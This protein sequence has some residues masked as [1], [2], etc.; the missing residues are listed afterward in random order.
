MKII[1]KQQNSFFIS[2]EETQFNDSN[3]IRESFQLPYTIETLKIFELNFIKFKGK[4][5]FSHFN[6]KIEINENQ[7]LIINN[8]IFYLKNHLLENPKT[9]TVFFFEQIPVNIDFEYFDFVNNISK[10]FAL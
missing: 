7:K 3:K 9:K 5:H 1:Q 10:E 6:N 2:P 8:Q 4:L